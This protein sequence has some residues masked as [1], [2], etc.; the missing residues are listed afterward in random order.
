MP[1]TRL[2]LTDQDRVG[3]TLSEGLNGSGGTQRC[4]PRKNKTKNNPDNL[5]VNRPIRNLLETNSRCRS[6]VNSEVGGSCGGQ[7]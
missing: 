5:S 7:T 2:K 3:D 1:A 6:L 4:H